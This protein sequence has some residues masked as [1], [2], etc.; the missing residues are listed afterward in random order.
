[1]TLIIENESDEVVV[2]AAEIMDAQGNMLGHSYFISEGI[3]RSIQREMYALPAWRMLKF[4][5]LERQLAEVIE[6][7]DLVE[8]VLQ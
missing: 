5:K 6:G 4:R 2:R 3:R 1:M 7:R 8:H